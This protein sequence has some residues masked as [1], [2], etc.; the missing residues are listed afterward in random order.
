MKRI[1]VILVMSAL[2]SMVSGQRSID[3][4]FEKYAGNDGFVTLTISGDLLNLLRSDEQKCRENHWPEKVTEI[5]VLVQDDE[6]LRVQN[7]YDIAMKD[8]NR[9][10]YEEYM[11]FKESDQEIRMFVRAEGDIIKEFLLIAGGDDNFIIQVKGKMTFRE[12]EE[13]S[14]GA[15]KNHGRDLL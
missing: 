10:D 2:M 6:S 3:A 4:I 13:F 12:A 9:K 8:I 14:S 5:R 7:F 1:L 15:R 11:S